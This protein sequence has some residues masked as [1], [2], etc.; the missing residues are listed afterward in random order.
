MGFDKRYL[1]KH[2]NQ[3]IVRIKVPERLRPFVGK[4]HL[5]HP[6]HTDSLAIANREKFAALAKLQDQL[7]AAEM[8]M[9]RGEGLPADA[10][11]A[12]G[13]EWQDAAQNARRRPEV[14]GVTIDGEEFLESEFDALHTAM[15][16]RAREIAS[17][18]GSERAKQFFEVASGAATPICSLGRVDE[19]DQG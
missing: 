8:Q 5:K 17:R 16:D 12:E 9:R 10:T 6:L 19:F 2:G 1:V 14:V 3:W 4:A 15:A 13:L 18:E 7:R 11:I